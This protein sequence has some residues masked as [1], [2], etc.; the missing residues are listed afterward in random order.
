M[1]NKVA[2]EQAVAETH[3]RIT[4]V[5]NHV[6]KIYE[7]KLE[8][9]ENDPEGVF[10]EPSP[11]MLTVASRFVKDNNITCQVE[12]SQEMGDLQKRLEA[13]RKRGKVLAS[14]SPIQQHNEA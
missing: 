6:L 9:Y 4:K 1:V 11:A 14:V 5:L 13:K 7:Q 10:L 2:T 3:G 8:E 12:E